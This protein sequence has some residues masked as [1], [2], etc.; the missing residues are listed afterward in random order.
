M[1]CLRSPESRSSSRGWSPT[2]PPLPRARH[3]QA[4]RRPVVGPAAAVLLDPPA[5]L[6]ERHEHD[7]LVVLAL[8]EL[9]EEPA[10]RVAD[11]LEQTR[12]PFGLVGVGVEAVDGDVEDAGAEPLF[13]EPGD[14]VQVVAQRT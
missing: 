7:L 12:V 1:A 6:R 9:L 8:P 13:D 4:R 3:E 5:E 11:L 10:D 2:A 14:Q